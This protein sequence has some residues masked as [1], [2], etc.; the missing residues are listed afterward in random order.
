MNS[1]LILVAMLNGQ[2]STT[3]VLEATTPDC[4]AELAVVRGINQALG[5]VA[6]QGQCYTAVARTNPVR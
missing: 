1:V 4:S 5:H 3:I 6:Y 2:P